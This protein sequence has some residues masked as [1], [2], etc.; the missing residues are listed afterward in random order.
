M[1]LK[2]NFNALIIKN[3]VSCEKEK[4]EM[5]KIDRIVNNKVIKNAIVGVSK[6]NKVR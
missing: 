2:L 1:Y 6:N 4:E 3:E 5:K